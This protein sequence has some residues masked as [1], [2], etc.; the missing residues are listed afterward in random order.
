MN[1]VQTL[2]SRR[3]TVSVKV[4]E[5]DN[6]FM[7]TIPLPTPYESQ[8]I[9][10]DT[11]DKNV[12]EDQWKAGGSLMLKALHWMDENMPV[13][14]GEKMS[15]NDLTEEEMQPVKEALNEMFFRASKEQVKPPSKK[16][17]KK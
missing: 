15:M 3:K 8:M 5:G 17:A 14:D 16:P 13:I 12:K 7:I 9:L 11:V 6:A 2:R 1:R 4:G 10:F